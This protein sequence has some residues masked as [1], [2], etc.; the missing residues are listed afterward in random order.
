MAATTEAYRN[1]HDKV[2][3]RLLDDINRLKEKSP[4]AVSE[5]IN[6]ETQDFLAGLKEENPA[7]ITQKQVKWIKDAQERLSALK[8]AYR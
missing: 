7:L 2:V 8:T 5:H 3:N 1:K 6:A 4:E